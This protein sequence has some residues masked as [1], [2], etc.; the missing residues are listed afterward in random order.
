[1]R[2]TMNK[3]LAKRISVKSNNQIFEYPIV[4]LD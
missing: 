1:L 3:L 4:H 2:P